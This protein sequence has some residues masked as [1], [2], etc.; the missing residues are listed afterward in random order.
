MVV[1]CDVS[2]FFSVDLPI[3]LITFITKW[4]YVKKTETQIQNLNKFK[5]WRPNVKKIIKKQ[6]KRNY[7]LQFYSTLDTRRTKKYSRKF[8]ILSI[9]RKRRTKRI[10][11]L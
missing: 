10:E 6:N 3:V 11:N 5:K 1:P 2:E 7:F 4:R 9:K 8:L